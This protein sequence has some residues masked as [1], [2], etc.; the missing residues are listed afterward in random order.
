MWVNPD[1]LCNSN[2]NYKAQIVFRG[3][4]RENVQFCIQHYIS[5]GFPTDVEATN[6]HGDI[7][8]STAHK[9]IRSRRDLASEGK[10][11]LTL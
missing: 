5:A 7:L 4:M 2:G 9:A 1:S 8:E 6:M 3:E 10:Y 11:Q